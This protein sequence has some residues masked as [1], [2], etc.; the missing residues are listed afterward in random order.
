MGISSFLA[1]DTSTDAQ[2][3]KKIVVTPVNQ[4]KSAQLTPC[5]AVQ[6]RKIDE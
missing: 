4:R 1:C 6:Q 2:T 3:K 5:N